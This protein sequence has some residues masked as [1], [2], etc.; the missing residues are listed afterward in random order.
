[1][2]GGSVTLQVSGITAVSPDGNTP[3]FGTKT[4]RPVDPKVMGKGSR[5]IADGSLGAIVSVTTSSLSF[6]GSVN[7]GC[8]RN[9][10]TYWIL[11]KSIFRAF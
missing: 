6:P 10:T 8:G 1:M 3:A 7:H 9:S 11:T 4:P 2:G 5:K